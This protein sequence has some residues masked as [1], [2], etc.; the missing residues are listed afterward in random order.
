MKIILENH[1]SYLLS[2]LAAANL[3]A[4]NLTGDNDVM[5]KSSAKGSFDEVRENPQNVCW[6]NCASIRGNLSLMRR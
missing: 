2:A 5:R 1:E 6:H 3:T 4:A